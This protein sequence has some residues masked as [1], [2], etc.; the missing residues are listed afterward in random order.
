AYLSS[1]K[2]GPY[3][4]HTVVPVLDLRSSTPR[5]VFPRVNAY[6][7][8]VQNSPNGV[9]VDQLDYYGPIPSDAGSHLTVNPCQD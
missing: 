3:R 4:K 8:D 7:S 1:L 6:W 2:G 5:Y 9:S